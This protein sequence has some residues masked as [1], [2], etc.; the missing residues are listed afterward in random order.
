MP[1]YSDK[2]KEQRKRAAKK[3]TLIHKDR[4]RKAVDKY[5][6]AHKE[7]IK[8]YHLKKNYGIN[9]E[10]FKQMF[11]AQETKCA[12]C[13]K[14]FINNKDICVD[15]NHTTKQVRQL[16]CKTCNWMIGYAQDNPDILISGAEYLN[17]WNKTSL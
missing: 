2:Q 14:S 6:A 10:Q 5:Y 7:K 15:H 4:C 17:K 3:Y 11:I 9:M 13:H 16:L 8:E 12:I 1:D